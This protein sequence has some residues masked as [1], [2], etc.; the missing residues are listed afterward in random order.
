[1]GGIALR[2]VIEKSPQRRIERDAKDGR[3]RQNVTLRVF[4]NA[5]G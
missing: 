5:C 1:M 2:E 3:I 4:H